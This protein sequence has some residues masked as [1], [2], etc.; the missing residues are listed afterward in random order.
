MLEKELAAILEIEAQKKEQARIAKEQE[1]Q[2]LKIE[3]ERKAL[4]EEKAAAERKEREAKEKVE[5]EKRKLEQE[6]LAIER[7]EAEKIGMDRDLIRDKGRTG[8]LDH[9]P[10]EECHLLTM[11]AED[12]L[13]DPEAECAR[14][15]HLAYRASERNHDFG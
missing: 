13:G 10:D 1:E 4:E 8:Y 5:A 14:V 12:A 9:G 2:Q 11:F 6:R 7:A 15:R 3:A